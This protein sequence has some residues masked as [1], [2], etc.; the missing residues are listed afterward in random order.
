[1][2][3]DPPSSDLGQGLTGNRQEV[4]AGRQKAESGVCRQVVGA[5]GTVQGVQPVGA[6][7]LEGAWILGWETGRERG[8]RTLV[9]GTWG[10]GSLLT[11]C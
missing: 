8:G 9:V 6:P 1:M 7:G 4:H 2:P 10:P 3:G 11:H 5:P